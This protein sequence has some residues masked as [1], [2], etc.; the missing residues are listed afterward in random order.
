MF[1]RC[2]CRRSF[3]NEF[4]TR[5]PCYTLTHTLKKLHRRHSRLRNSL[6]EAELVFIIS[7]FLIFRKDPQIQDRSSLDKMFWAQWADMR[8]KPLTRQCRSL[9]RLLYKRRRTARGPFVPTSLVRYVQSTFNCSTELS[10]NPVDWSRTGCWFSPSDSLSL[11]CKAFAWERTDHCGRSTTGNMCDAT[12]AH[13]GR[14]IMNELRWTRIFGRTVE[15]L[16]PV[17]NVHKGL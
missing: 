4:T 13:A 12:T 3:L 7:L 15:Q 11:V 6:H 1:Q 5:W 9:W 17:Q 16:R 2:S 14:E 8:I 10:C